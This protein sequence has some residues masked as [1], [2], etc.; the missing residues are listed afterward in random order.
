MQDHNEDEELDLG[1]S[2]S[3]IKRDMQAL[4][5]LG[6]TLVKLSTKDLAKI[7]LPEKLAGAIAHAKELRSNSAFKR[8]I[9]FIGKIIRSLDMAPVLQ[10]LDA[11]RQCG[12]Q[13]TSHFHAIEQWRDRIINEGQSALNEFVGQHPE[14]DR[15]QLRQLMLNAAKE[16]K[17]GKP[18]KS[19][20]NLF[21]LLRELLDTDN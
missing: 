11:I 19:A 14:V 8:Q 21:K 15:Q 10:A 3:Q 7:P 9:Q 16:A 18:P 1:P 13:S 5:D 20:R 12:Q 4:Q 2:R 17:Q 6:S